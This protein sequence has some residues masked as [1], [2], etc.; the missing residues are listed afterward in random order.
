MIGLHCSLESSWSENHIR[1]TASPSCPYCRFNRFR[2]IGPKFFSCLIWFAGSSLD[3]RREFFS[4][5]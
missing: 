2:T 1:P 3:R 4:C 5:V